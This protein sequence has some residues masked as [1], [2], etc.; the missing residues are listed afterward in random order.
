MYLYVIIKRIFSS[1]FLSL[2]NHIPIHGSYLKQNDMSIL[3]L[4]ATG[5]MSRDHPKSPILIEL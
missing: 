3:V 5:K 2:S 4:G 1:I